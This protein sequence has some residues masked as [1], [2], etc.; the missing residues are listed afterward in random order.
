MTVT[1]TAFQ[2]ASFVELP[3]RQGLSGRVLGAPEEGNAGHIRDTSVDD[4]SANRLAFMRELDVAADDLTLARQTHGVRIALAGLADRGRGRPPD[5]DGFPETDGIITDVPGVVLG[6]T[7][8]DCV[9]LLLYDQRQ[10]AVGLVHAGW[11]GTVAGIAACAVDAMERAFGSRPEELRAGIGPSIGP[12]CYEV[13]DEVID[14]WL[15]VGPGSRACAL[16]PG[17][18]A[19]RHF[20]LWTAN[21]LQL[22][23]AGILSRNVEIAG[24]CVKCESGRFFS[25]RAVMTGDARRGLMLMIAQLLPVQHKGGRT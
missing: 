23:E 5:Y 16:A 1:H 8:A 17:R 18:A 14:A 4:V 22:H 13:G 10:H 15:A 9:P 25:H 21:A 2:F 3:I 12:C 24:R 7:V 20:D 6:I 11:R 19:K